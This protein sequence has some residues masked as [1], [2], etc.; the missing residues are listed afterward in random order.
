MKS[1]V[2]S[3]RKLALSALGAAISLAAVTAAFYIKNLSLSFNVL[4]A[5]GLLL[6]LSQKYYREAVLA[7]IA[8]SGIGAIYTT[9]N[10]LPFVL[11][12]GGY[13]LFAVI[14]YE[15]K[16]KPYIVYP[17]CAA[18]SALV[19]L[20]F[21]KLTGLL[22]VNLAAFKIDG[23]APWAVYIVLNLLFSLFFFAY[24]FLII[25]VYRYLKPVFDKI[26]GSKR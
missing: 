7:Y 14:S 22:Y 18:Y 1:P 9:V 20:V 11:V 13:T 8:V 25:W 4:A 23:W 16:L 17:V 5:A 26:S 10:I 24:H 6:P 21:Y 15:K 2:F 12:T 19:F 3:S